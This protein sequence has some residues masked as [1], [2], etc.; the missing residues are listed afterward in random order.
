MVAGTRSIRTTVASRKIADG[1]P[2][3]EQ[4]EGA[5]VLEEEAAEDER[6]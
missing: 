2:D 1:Q 3:A 5:V 6:P 4:L